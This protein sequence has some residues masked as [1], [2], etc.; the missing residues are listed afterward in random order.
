MVDAIQLHP[1]DDGMELLHVTGDF[2]LPVKL[3]GDCRDDQGQHVMVRLSDGSVMDG[4][5]NVREEVFVNSLVAAINVAQYMVGD[6]SAKDGSNC[7]GSTFLGSNHCMDGIVLII[8]F[9]FCFCMGE[10]VLGGIT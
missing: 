8:S 3:E 2:L 6:V 1:I 5:Y 9:N 7:L 10:L 4:F